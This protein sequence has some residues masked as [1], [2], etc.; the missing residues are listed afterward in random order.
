MAAKPV[1]QNF[2]SFAFNAFRILP[3]AKQRFNAFLVVSLV[4]P[5]INKETALHVFSD[6]LSIKIHSSAKAVQLKTAPT[7]MKIQWSVQ[8]V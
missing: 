6:H 8:P 5:A 2:H 7:A 3:S 4:P 1:T